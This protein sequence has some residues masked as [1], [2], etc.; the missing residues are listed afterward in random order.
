[1]SDSE[2][3]WTVACQAPLYMGFSRQDYWRGLPCLPPG[4]PP[5]LRIEPSSLVSPALRV[6]SLPLVPSSGKPNITPTCL[7]LCRGKYTHIYVY[8]F[9]VVPLDYKKQKYFLPQNRV[10]KHVVSETVRQEKIDAS[11]FNL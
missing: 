5:D 3:P 6:D 1:M 11:H 9:Y 2:T 7:K 8:I 4:D 10:I